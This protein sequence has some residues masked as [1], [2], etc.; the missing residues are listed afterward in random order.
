MTE[1]NTVNL[2]Y[3]SSSVRRWV[4]NSLNPMPVSGCGNWERCLVVT[5]LV[6]EAGRRK[7]ETS[8]D[9]RV[10]VPGSGELSPSQTEVRGSL[11]PLSPVIPNRRSRE[12][13]H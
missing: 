2:Y 13:S 1:R 10:C 12:Q 7:R 6:T 4:K 8:L 9:P 3:D 11:T 5:E